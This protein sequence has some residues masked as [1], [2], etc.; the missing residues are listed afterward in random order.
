MTAKPLVAVIAGGSSSERA[1]SLRSAQSVLAACDALGYPRL[2][3]DLDGTFIDS[4]RAYRPAVAFNALHGGAGEDGTLA[5]LLEFLHLPYQ[6]SGVRASAIAMDKWLTKA[7]M[8]AEDIPTPAAQLMRMGAHLTHVVPAPVGLP[9]VIK[10]A[11]QGSALGV[12]I[13]RSAAEWQ[14]ALSKA[15]IYGDHLV[16]E[17]YVEGREFTVAIL[18]DEALPVV[19]IEPRDRF[20]T[21]DAK[22]TPGA[23]VHTVPARI[24]PERAA[25]MQDYALRL[26]RALGCR[27]YSRI[28]VLAA[29]DLSALYVLECNT[30]PGLTPLSLF[31]DAAAAADISYDALIGRL[32][33]NALNRRRALD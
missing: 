10:P 27:D 28:D 6:G 5:A 14:A 24:P 20:Y 32:I 13:V 30:L 22:Y 1:V 23:S 25:R 17:R 3:L 12:S 11:A 18:D 26:H 8:R 33:G 4:V 21:Y 31:P 29:D 7:V 19:E 2:S 15:S 9:C 16:V